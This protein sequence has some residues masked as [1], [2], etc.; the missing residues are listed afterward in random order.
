MVPS[1]EGSEVKI[2][3]TLTIPANSSLKYVVNYTTDV[4]W[5][6]ITDISVMS[7][8]ELL[9]CTRVGPVTAVNG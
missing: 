3:H 4:T 5:L 1:Q 2:L 6:E 8:G 9:L 7:V